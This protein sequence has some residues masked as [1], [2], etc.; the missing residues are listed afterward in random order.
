MK[1][2]KIIPF[3]IATHEYLVYSELGSFEQ[4][5]CIP[6]VVLSI[7]MI[8]LSLLLRTIGNFEQGIGIPAV[9]PSITMVYLSL[10]LRTREL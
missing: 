1:C 6:A 2:L 3:S 4:G 10:L 7:T 5:I 9:V 8:Y